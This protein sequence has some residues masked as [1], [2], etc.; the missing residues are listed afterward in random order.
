VTRHPGTNPDG[1]A[2]AAEID[3]VERLTADVARLE[4]LAQRMTALEREKSEFLQ[5]ASHELRA[6]IT[7]V[8]GYLS[9]LEDG[10]LG[11]LPA[12]AAQVLPLLMARM[13]RMSE[14]V[15]RMLTTSRLELRARHQDA[16]DIDMDALARSVAAAARAD[17]AAARVIRVDTTGQVLV[18]ADPEVV[19]TI[20]GN[21]VS[22]ALKYSPDDRE[23]TIQV[24]GEPA[25]VAVQVTDRGDGITEEDLLRLFQPFARLPDA[26]AAG[27]PGTGLGLH[28]SRG[29]AQ[30]QG[31]D[32][33]VTSRPGEGS[34]FTLRLPREQEHRIG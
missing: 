30:A 29:L 31:G 8:S 19:E 16:G 20:L 18:R 26:V 25:S 14:L 5:L 22:N 4:A 11:V 1:V 21:L 33:E 28:L 2:G 7:L 34:T 23:V 32:I 24:R 10:S 6:P 27:V 12:D 9:M 15:E 17:G 3:V 13:R